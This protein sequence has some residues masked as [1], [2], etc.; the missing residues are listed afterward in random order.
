MTHGRR[1]IE[2]AL[3]SPGRAFHLNREEQF[4]AMEEA[5]TL[6]ERLGKSG[7]QGMRHRYSP[8]VAARHEL[9]RAEMEPKLLGLLVPGP[10]RDA[11]GRS[12]S[13]ATSVGLIQDA[14]TTYPAERSADV[15]VRCAADA[16]GKGNE[17]ALTI[18]RLTIDDAQTLNCQS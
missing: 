13:A 14:L 12:S 5:E 1:L 16:A 15:R 3:G 10:T 4:Q 7:R 8:K 18:Y 17:G 2:L 11:P 6:W 9:G